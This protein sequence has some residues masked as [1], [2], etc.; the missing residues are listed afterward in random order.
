MLKLLM[1]TAALLVLGSSPGLAGPTLYKGLLGSWCY[2]SS[3]HGEDLYVEKS[4]KGCGGGHILTFK[5]DRYEDREY[6]CL[7]TAIKIKFNP[8][9]PASTK[10]NGVNVSHI[11]ARCAGDGC[12]WMEQMTAYFQQGQ[13]M[14]KQRQYRTRCD[15]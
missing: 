8:N 10:E 15:D 6:G 2:H 11:T 7:I 9:I 5:S 4:D 12:T 3:H 13:F 14:V 1:L